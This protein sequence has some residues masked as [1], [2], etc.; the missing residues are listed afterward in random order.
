[1]S[2][3]MA[4]PPRLTSLEVESYKDK[5]NKIDSPSELLFKEYQAKKFMKQQLLEQGIIDEDHDEE[6]ILLADS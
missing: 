3:R 5:Y 6:D 4:T 1:M 2:G